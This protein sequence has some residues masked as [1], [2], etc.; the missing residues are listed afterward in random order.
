M[1]IGKGIDGPVQQNSLAHL[2]RIQIYLFPF[3]KIAEKVSCQYSRLIKRQI[4]V[5]EIVQMLNNRCIDNITFYNG[6]KQK[7]AKKN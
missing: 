6:F 4:C 7:N 3:Y 5:R 2:L 1:L